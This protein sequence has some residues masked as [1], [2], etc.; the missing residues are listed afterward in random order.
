[1]HRQSILSLFK[2][3]KD[4]FPEE[5]DTVDR[6]T[7]F[8]EANEKCF[9]RELL[10]GHITGSAW[11][12]DAA[13]DRALLT[14]HRKLNIWVQLGGHADGDADVQ[15]VAEREAEEESG[16]SQIETLSPD[17]FDIDIHHIPARKDEPAHYHYDC[18]FL[19]QA[20]AHE[21]TVS[22]ESHDLSWIPLDRMQDYSNEESVLRM[23][24][25]TRGWSSLTQKSLSKQPV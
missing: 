17:I 16:I 14:H 24:R 13:G 11:I 12:L 19:L 8:V 6:I 2:R 25:K 20:K 15:R 21:Y 18:R 7:T 1:M 4:R 23:V 9:S 5:R 22:D 10:T 3:Y